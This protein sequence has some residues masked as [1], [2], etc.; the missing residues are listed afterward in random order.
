MKTKLNSINLV[1]VSPGE[2]RDFYVN[3]LDFQE[4]KKRS[5]APGFF[6]IEG[7]NGCNILIQQAEYAQTKPG[8]VGFELGMEVESL[9]E[10]YN[11][12]KSSGCKIVAGTQ[13]MDWGKGVTIEDPEGHIINIYQF[14][15]G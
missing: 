7:G 4:D 13:Q 11:N 10:F 2:L 14:L 1:S 6:F 3:V 8:N 9:D 12:I 15:R 5:H